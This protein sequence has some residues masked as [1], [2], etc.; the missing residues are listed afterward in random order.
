[1]GATFGKGGKYCKNWELFIIQVQQGLS[2]IYDTGLNEYNLYAKCEVPKFKGYIYSNK[3]FVY[4]LPSFG[5]RKH[6]HMI[7]KINVSIPR[8]VYSLEISWFIYSL[9]IPWLDNSSEIPWL[10]YSLEIPWLF[11]SLK[12]HW[13]FY[14]L[15]IPCYVY[16]LEIPWLVYSL[17]I[18]WLVYS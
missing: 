6:P 9:E 17:E 5:H 7:K 4:D 15:E 8:L 2:I 11:N 1:M 12:I 10:V 18:S 3:S 16:S 14:S 13:L